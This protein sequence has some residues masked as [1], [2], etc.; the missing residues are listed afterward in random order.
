MQKHITVVTTETSGQFHGEPM[1]DTSKG[2]LNMTDTE[3]VEGTIATFNWDHVVGYVESPCKHNE[4]ETD[5]Y[6]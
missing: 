4:D 1:L 2:T 3:G 5:G 6:L